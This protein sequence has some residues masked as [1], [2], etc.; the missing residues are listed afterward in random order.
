M[1]SPAPTLVPRTLESASI[2]EP[3]PHVYG[4]SQAS[5]VVLFRDEL[6]AF[7]GVNG[8][9]CDAGFSTDTHGVVW[10]SVDG[11]AWRI[12]AGGAPFA[13]G[14]I[15]GAAE[16]SDHVVA[17]GTRHLPDEG[18]PEPNLHG[19]VWTSPDGGSWELIRDTPIFESIVA[20]AD[21]FVAVSN[22]RA[23]PEIWRSESGR[24]WELVA[25][26]EVLGNGRVDRLLM[27]D[28][29]LLAVG[30][31]INPYADLALEQDVHAP[32]A[33]WRSPDGRAWSRLPADPA[34]ASSR[35][36]NVAAAGG[37]LLAVGSDTVLERSVAWT[38]TD[39]AAW[40]RVDVPSLDGAVIRLT[41]VLGLGDGF[42]VFGGWSPAEQEG[43]DVPVIWTTQDGRDWQPL[44]GLENLQEV[45]F[46]GWLAV[47]DGRI[48]IVGGAWDATAGRAIPMAWILS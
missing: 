37:R 22:T 23:F 7:G 1:A 9:C 33:I 30:W 44:A 8:G 14:A 24:T 17:V 45:A 3:L 20:T 38:S 18:A 47:P 41:S 26:Q 21:G 13:L 36:L 16:S 39:A 25:G 27:T 31:S 34:L 19:A 15:A 43:P 42:A 32:A 11:A 10:T 12:S 29:G 46:G 2:E 6:L 48:L 40:D 4:G 5:A 28:D 35:I